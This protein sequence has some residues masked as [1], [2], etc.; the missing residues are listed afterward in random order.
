MNDFII[1]IEAFY[2]ASPLVTKLL[3]GVITYF[4]VSSIVLIIVLL[5][6]RYLRRKISREKKIL[7]QKYETMIADFTFGE[8]ED[9]HFFS[10]INSPYKRDV[11]LETLHL[12]SQNISG[13]YAEV[14]QKI[15][16]QLDLSTIAVRYAKSKKWHFQIY[17]I[18]IIGDFLDIKNA[19]IVKNAY[20][21][22]S[23]HVRIASELSIIKLFPLSP[24]DFL[25]NTKYPLNDWAQINILTA[26][27]NCPQCVIPDF[28]KWYSSSQISVSIFAVRMT[29][30]YK[31]YENIPKLL[32]LIPVSSE[33]LRYE[34]YVALEKMEYQHA[35]PIAQKQFLTE[36]ETNKIAILKM[37]SKTNDNNAFDFLLHLLNTE[38]NNH[39]LFHIAESLCGFG[40]EGLANIADFAYNSKNQPLKSGITYL[41]K[42]QNQ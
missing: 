27:E 14:L 38:K 25:D 31:Q 26:L 32:D 10:E 12:F 6:A 20:H 2:K 15:Y 22:K 28:S 8:I 37:I 13:E 29:A 11:F 33:I 24:L 19:E 3:L 30:S 21:S 5:I 16:N 17:G 18:K 39:I 42:I 1:W 34:I 9:I 7:I 41:L 40:K 36:T 4:V 23:P 35:L